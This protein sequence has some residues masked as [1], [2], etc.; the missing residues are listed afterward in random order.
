MTPKVKVD[1]DQIEDAA[2]VFGSQVGPDIF[3]ASSTIAFAM[4]GGMAGN[5]EAGDSWSSSYD[6]AAT[7]VHGR[8][9]RPRQQQLQA[10]QHAAHHR[11]QPQTR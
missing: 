10:G 4:T 5:D 11:R 2:D 3:N 6:Q 8:D 9:G 7:A 1:I